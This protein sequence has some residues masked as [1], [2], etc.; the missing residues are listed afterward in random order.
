MA[1]T[2]HRPE[3][4]RIEWRLAPQ[5]VLKKPAKDEPAGPT[6][7]LFRPAGPDCQPWRVER[8]ADHPLR[9]WLN[10]PGEMSHPIRHSIPW[11]LS[12][13]TLL[14]SRTL[15]RLPVSKSRR[16]SLGPRAEGRFRSATVTPGGDL[17][18]DGNVGI[19]WCSGLASRGL[20]GPWR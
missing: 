17:T 7:A 11:P 4:F 6:R 9:V 15:A 10:R 16:S 8:V 19:N 2:A 3:F 5:K 12:P 1:S 20:P 18:Y 13:S 14:P